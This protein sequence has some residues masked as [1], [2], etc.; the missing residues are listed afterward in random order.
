MQEQR[1]RRLHGRGA[2]LGNVA[3]G[4]T[5]LAQPSVAWNSREDACIFATLLSRSRLTK[6]QEASSYC[7]LSTTIPYDPV[8]SAPIRMRS[9]RD[10][11][12]AHC[13]NVNSG[14]ATNPLFERAYKELLGTGLARTWN[15]SASVVRLQSLDGTRI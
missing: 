10:S 3:Q 14:E 5:G 1:K 7:D 2:V 12:A 6:P 9:K 11:L 15:T 8:N 4:A 13:T